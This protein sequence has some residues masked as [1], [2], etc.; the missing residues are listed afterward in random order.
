MVRVVA[1]ALAGLVLAS[2][3]VPAQERLPVEEVERIVRE[4]LLREPEVLFEALQELQ[5]RREA[6]EAERQK[7]LL[8]ERRSELVADPEDPVLGDPRGD[9]TL[10][11]FSDYRCGYCRSM[12]PALRSLLQQDRRLKLVI[13]EFPILGPDSV[14]AS[15]A[16]LAA[17]RQG[18]YAELHWALFQSKDLSEGA[19]LD[20]ARRLGLDAERLARD[21][22]DPAI[23]R[24]LERVRALADALGI[25]G[26]PSFV[27]GDTLVP[28][29]APLARLVE[30]IGR[31]RRKG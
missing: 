22:R 7:M 6:A 25:S 1:G 2:G 4:Y 28:G 9:A 27:V 21:M 19:I 14:T 13:K 17:R 29:A 15:R 26:T 24:H 16:A 23:E 5:R 3:G 31:Q 30:L 18:R 11:V 10:V 12:A 8:E 20:L